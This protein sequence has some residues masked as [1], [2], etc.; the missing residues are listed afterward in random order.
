MKK[1][2]LNVCLSAL[3]CMISMSAWALEKSGNVY[4][5]GSAEDLRA[6]AELVNGGENL[7][8]AVLTADVKCATDQ[9][10][11]GVGGKWFDGVFDGQGHTITL[12]AYPQGDS[13]GVFSH[14]GY[15]G[16]VRNLVVDGKITTAGRWNAGVASDSRGAITNCISKVEIQSAYAGDNTH[17]GIV[18]VF[19]MGAVVMNCLSVAH[20]TGETAT[21]C[22][23]LI[24]WMDG[25]GVVENNLSIAT[26]EI[27]PDA[28][29][30]R[31][32]ARN[33]DN[34]R[35]GK[36][37]YVTRE[38]ETSDAE[39][40]QITEEQLK[41][42]AVCF[43]LNS[44]QSDIQWTQ[45]LGEDDYP[46]PFKTRK[47]VFAS[48]AG[49]C[50]GEVPEGTTFNN[51]SGAEC[52]KHNLVAG[53]CQNTFFDEEEGEDYTCYYWDPFFVERDDEG[54]LVLKTVQDMEWYAKNH[55]LGGEYASSRLYADIDYTG[56]DMWINSNWFSG[57]FDG[58]GHTIKIAFP[59]R[60]IEGDAVDASGT[61]NALFPLV[62]EGTIKNLKVTGTIETSA[63]YASGLV[64]HTMNGT[65]YTSY[66]QNCITDVNITSTLS[67][68]G[69]HGG[70]IAVTDGLV[71]VDNCIAM[72]TITSPDHITTCCGGLIGWTNTTS[73]LNNCA[74]LGVLDVNPEG[75]DVITRNNGNSNITNTYYLNDAVEP[76]TIPGPAIQTTANAVA[77]GE[78]TYLLNKNNPDGAF[79]QTIG[80]DAIPMP[81][82]ASQKVY[83]EPSGGF[84]CDGVPQG[85]VSY[86][87]TESTAQI[88]P[89]TFN[90]A[91]CEVCGYFN[92]EFKQPNADGVYELA[93]AKDLVWFSQKVNRENAGKLSAK[94]TAD[95][96][97]E[98]EDNERFQ[99]IGSTSNLY[100]GEF[101]GQFH[102][103]SNLVIET[104]GA[105]YTGMFGCVGGGV[106][107]KNFTLDAT[108][109]ISGGA[110]T[111]V[112]GGSNG[113][114]EVRF[115]QIG[116]EG[117]VTSTA[118]NAGGIYGCNMSSAATP[119]IENCYVTGKV[120]GANESGQISGWAASGQV[121]NCWSIAELEGVDG[122]NWMFRG[123]PTQENN[124][125]TLGQVNGL[126]EE[127]LQSGA[128]AW[129]L[130]K[131][132]FAN[133]VWYQNVGE[134]EHPVLN[135]THGVVYSF[136]G[137]LGCEVF[138]V[139]AIGVLCELAT[140]LR[141][142]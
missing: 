122:E 46:V 3:V 76:M 30:T 4:Q 8:N 58:Q 124:Y 32:I 121:R 69:T 33:A 54:Y 96:Q 83:A 119:I 85:N 66:I 116:N 31:S 48:Q 51:E 84:R 110:F 135:P 129:K 18:A 86:T 104:N 137:E 107:I 43:A 132:K 139:R 78:L 26:I 94:L 49:N 62:G 77:S 9:P 41:S 29:N 103:I 120:K 82:G 65:S 90:G 88:P 23:G 50:Q 75:S 55:E 95:I 52:Q 136:G 40:I 64:G 72:G 126:T 15:K 99:P 111:G 81:F 142:V 97:M 73:Y 38:K 19:R 20:I 106:V 45:T 2:L 35:V 109:S 115:L 61:N 131:E 67:G 98:D 128:L 59:D 1:R 123:S 37:F 12:D 11:I 87:N 70:L 22:A 102:T 34:I 68:D 71:Y 130:N 44:D 114:G 63:K 16:R 79:R 133:V 127:D 42:G 36:N 7:A 53:K 89:H 134:D 118:Q 21:N 93:N 47:Q 138:E 74:A 5:I 92:S 28:G 112:I 125:S 60:H 17:A 56:H 25:R 101:D 24:G 6:F 141:G 140:K 39:G 100:T 117:T 57:V 10:M 14:I 105:Q 113:S 27:A 13:C 80:T 91:F 108:C